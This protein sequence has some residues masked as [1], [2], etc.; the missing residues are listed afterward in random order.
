M[1]TL[2]ADSKCYGKSSQYIARITGRDPKFTF[3]REFIGRKSGKRGDTTSADVDEPGLYEITDIDRKGNK[4]SAYRILAL[5]NGELLELFGTRDS[6]DGLD[7]KDAAM[8]IAKR[9]DGG[10]PF[11]EIVEVLEGGKY[12]LRSKAEAKRA[13]AAVTVD[14]AVEQCWTVLQALPE[15]EAKRVLKALRDRMAPP[16]P[17]QPEITYRV[18]TGTDGQ[19]IIVAECGEASA[20]YLVAAGSYSANP[21]DT[22]QCPATEDG[23]W[24]APP[25]D[26]IAQA[27]LH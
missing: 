16:K 12:R 13:S 20:L 18:D 10:E 27:K 1:I 3:N 24:P 11:A 5:R 21:A 22:D 15:R 6:A 14:A 25:E 4:N 9:M 17:A 7:G 2:T 19:A 8:Q 23:C 26:V